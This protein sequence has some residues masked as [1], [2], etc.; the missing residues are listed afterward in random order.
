[1]KTSLSE[2]I[3]HTSLI[4]FAGT[5]RGYEASL[6]EVFADNVVVGIGAVAL[7]VAGPIVGIV[8]ARR[9]RTKLDR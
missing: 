9:I 6:S 5:E 8:A 3:K 1:M 7:L 4:I 2:W